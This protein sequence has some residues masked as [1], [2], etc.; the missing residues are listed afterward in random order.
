MLSEQQLVESLDIS[1]IEQS[2]IDSDSDSN[3]VDDI[4]LLTC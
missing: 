3:S 2:L 1:D 4:C